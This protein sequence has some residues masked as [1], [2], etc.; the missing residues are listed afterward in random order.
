MTAIARI[1]VVALGL[2][3]AAADAAFHLW[4]MTEIYSNADGTVQ[5]LELASPSDGEGLVFGHTLAVIV[6][7]TT[8]TFTFPDNVPGNT[9]NK[10]MLIATEGFAAL[11]VVTPDFVVPDGF[12][13]AAGGIVSFAGVDIWSHPALPT[14]GFASLQRAGNV[15]LG[16]PTNFAGRTGNLASPSLNFQGLWYKA[17]A[18]SE[19]GWGVNISHQ[20]DTFFVTWFTY[21]LDGSQMWLVGPAVRRTTGNT[22]AGD[23]FRTTG[24]AFDAVPFGAVGASAAGTVTFSFAD[25]NNGTFGYTVGNVTQSKAITRQVFDTPPTCTAGGQAG[26]AP[27][28]SDLWY[29]APAESEPGWGVN[30]TQ[31]ANVIF[32][33]WFTY[34]ATGRG[35]WVVGPRMERTTGDTFAGALF[36]TTGPAYNAV[37]WNPAGVAAVAVGNATLAFTDAN[38]GTFSYTMTSAGPP[39][40]QVKAIT[41]QVFAAPATVCR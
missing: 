24:P 3:S 35:M 9:R 8:R 38:T 30:V 37:P 25:A 34:D 17:P 19:S 6:G 28:F 41:R 13:S 31:Q 10:S 29:R 11:G 27:N 12:F 7:N 5:F 40:Q 23:I 39:V 1:L 15:A 2:F 18:E 14:T 32:A 22:Y 16:T 4:R 26:A 36:R 20:G 33:A 21:D